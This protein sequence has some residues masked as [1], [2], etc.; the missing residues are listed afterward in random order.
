[1]GWAHDAP[2]S[3]RG[4]HVGAPPVH[5]RVR[6][7]GAPEHFEG[8]LVP[9]GEALAV[10]VEPGLGRPVGVVRL[11]HLAVPPDGLKKLQLVEGDHGLHVTALTGGLNSSSSPFEMPGLLHHGHELVEGRAGVVDGHLGPLEWGHLDRLKG[12]RRCSSREP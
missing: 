1:M 12:A 8:Q 5:H 10:D 7:G 2:V 4:R 9:V 6:V 3:L 11:D